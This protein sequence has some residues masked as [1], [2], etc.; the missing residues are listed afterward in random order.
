MAIYTLKKVYPTFDAKSNFIAESA[1][2]IGTV[3][4]HP[5][6]NIWFQA[7]IRGD[8]ELIEIG[9]NTNIQDGCMLHTDMG[10]PMKIGKNCTIGHKAILH[11]CIIEEN[12]LIGMGATILNGAH[13]GKNCIIGAGALISE[14]KIIPDNS[15]VIGMPGKIARQ[16]TEDESQKITLSASHYVQNA[17]H[18]L[19]HLKYYEHE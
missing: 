2:I 9:E 10:Y 12:S 4:L 17:K 15:L 7:I 8:N 1:D 14:N 19:E 11:G 6:A 18:Y 16:I 5:H 13:I 3:V